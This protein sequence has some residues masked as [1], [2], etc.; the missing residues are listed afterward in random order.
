MLPPLGHRF[1]Y[2]IKLFLIYKL[3]LINLMFFTTDKQ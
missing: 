3:K 1:V 2:N